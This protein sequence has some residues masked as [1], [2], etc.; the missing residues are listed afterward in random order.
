MP[1]RGSSAESTWRA[2]PQCSA[3]AAPSRTRDLGLLGA[4]K[5]WKRLMLGEGMLQNESNGLRWAEQSFKWNRYE[6][7]W[8]MEDYGGDRW[9]RKS[10]KAVLTNAGDSE[11]LPLWLNSEDE[12]AMVPT[13]TPSAWQLRQNLETNSARPSSKGGKIRFLLV[14]RR[15][16]RLFSSSVKPA[17]NSSGRID[18]S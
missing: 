14:G 11:D 2:R 1:R 12:S 9:L 8:T 15:R 13:Q 16:N 6:Q 4:V 7:M 18:E 3:S 5:S 10:K 17:V